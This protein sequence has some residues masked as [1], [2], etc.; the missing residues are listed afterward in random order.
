MSTSIISSGFYPYTDLANSASHSATAVAGDIIFITLAYR[1]TASALFS[2]PTWNGQAAVPCGA[3]T[4]HCGFFLHDFYIKADS[5]AT[6]NITTASDNYTYLNF[7]FSVL[8]SSLVAFPSNPLKNYQKSFFDGYVDVMGV[9]V[10]IEYYD[11]SLT[12]DVSANDIVLATLATAGWEPDFDTP[13]TTYSAGGSATLIGSATSTVH[14]S[15]RHLY[16][17]NYSGA[18]S[19]VSSYTRSDSGTPMYQFSTAVFYEAAQQITSINGGNPITAGQTGIA[20]VAAGFPSKPDTLTATYA[21]GTKSITATIDAGGTAN[22]FTMSVQ[23]RIEAEDWPLNNSDVTYTFSVGAASASLTQALV[24]KPSETVLTFAGAI[25]SDPATLTYWLTQDGFT[26]EGGENVYKQPP[27]TGT[28]PS[29]DLVLTADGGGSVK[30]A[31]AFTSWFRPASGTG[32]GNVY[33]YQWIITE[34]GISP[35]ISNV[36]AKKIS[37]RKISATKISSRGV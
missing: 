3:R 31:S 6:A 34:A 4:L 12:N 24:K 7:G 2:S 28:M 29:P 18:G 13:S 19:T 37:C 17:S 33:E 10:P 32:A 5:S 27:P 35:A 26:V 30:E 20:I 23:D 14:P 21:G 11:P 25:T 8:R 15:L 36:F 9:P 22:N 1:D 16:L